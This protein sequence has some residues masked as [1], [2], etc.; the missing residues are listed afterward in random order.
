MLARAACQ[1][2]LVVVA[3]RDPGH[4]LPG[5]ADLAVRGWTGPLGENC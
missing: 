1:S 4:Y 5:V 2:V 3:G